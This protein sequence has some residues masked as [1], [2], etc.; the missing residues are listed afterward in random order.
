MG[1]NLQFESKV[2]QDGFTQIQ[3]CVLRSPKLSMQSKCLY[4]Q[5]LSYAWN[6]TG[7]PGRDR[8]SKENDVHVNSI[9]AYMGELK[10]MGLIEVKRRGVGLTNLYTIKNI[11]PEIYKA[12]SPYR[13]TAE[14]DTESQYSVSQESQHTVRKEYEVKKDKDKEYEV[15]KNKPLGQQVDQSKF[16]ELWKSYPKKIDKKKALASY[17]RAIKK[18]TSHETIASGLHNYLKYLGINKS[19]LKPQDGGRWFDKERWNDEYDMT[20]PANGQF[21]NQR[22]K[23]GGWGNAGDGRNQAASGF[24]Y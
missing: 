2:H 19:W 7:F 15:K 21:N 4:A 23:T 20:P 14:C 17:T 3:N 12:L 8:L 11:T 24:K 22:Q 16:D 10:K 6:G 13:F 18:G 5:I 9:D 1:N